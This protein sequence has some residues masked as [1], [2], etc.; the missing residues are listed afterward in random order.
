MCVYERQ[1]TNTLDTQFFSLQ[2][3]LAV[4]PRFLPP[5][6]FSS[7]SVPPCFVTQLLPSSAV[8]HIRIQRLFCPPALLPRQLRGEVG[9]TTLAAL[10]LRVTAATTP[11]PSPAQQDRSVRSLLPGP[12]ATLLFV[13]PSVAEKPVHRR[14]AKRT[15]CYVVAITTGRCTDTYCI[16]SS[17]Y[18][19]PSL[20]RPRA[21]LFDPVLPRFSPLPDFGTERRREEKNLKTKRAAVC[22][23]RKL[24]ATPDNIVAPPPLPCKEPSRARPVKSLT[25]PAL[26]NKC[27]SPI[28][29]PVSSSFFF[30][31]CTNIFYNPQVQKTTRESSVTVRIAHKKKCGMA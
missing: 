18:R 31:G 15:R 1:R 3:E 13:A 19:V 27:T 10:A 25:W 2:R 8:S 12:L 29:I 22:V 11:S 5:L 21:F 9:S 30:K 23:H 26:F 14:S 6:S 28:N 7:S 17:P 20:R 24:E 4:H 16:S